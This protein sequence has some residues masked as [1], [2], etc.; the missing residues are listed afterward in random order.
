MGEEVGENPAA[1]RAAV[2]LLS[3]KNRR[4]GVQTP[5]PPSRAKVKSASRETPF[6]NVFLHPTRGSTCPRAAG[7]IS[8]RMPGNTA[9]SEQ[10]RKS[11]PRWDSVPPPYEWNADTLPTELM[12]LAKRRAGAADGTSKLKG[13]RIHGTRRN[14]RN[15]L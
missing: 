5:P 14:C 8:T 2:F 15:E 12:R 6:R 4:G 9:Y 1:L 11:K 7:D 10:K 13:G 3:A